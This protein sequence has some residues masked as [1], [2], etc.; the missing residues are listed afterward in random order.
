MQYELTGRLIFKTEAIQRSEKFKTREF[1]VEVQETVKDKTFSQLIKL[2][3][4]Q[5][6]TTV[7]DDLNI[8]DEVKVHFN[9]R[10]SKWE[11]DGKTSY[12][13]NLDAWK[14][15]KLHSAEPEKKEEFITE[16]EV[17]EP[18]DDLPF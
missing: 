14:I 17:I 9:L 10:G 12:F 16:A 1:V 13:T 3:A 18:A 6:R 4:S 7:L 15:E 5:E 2:Q 8:G 11:K